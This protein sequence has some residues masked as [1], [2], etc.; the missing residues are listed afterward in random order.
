MTCENDKFSPVSIQ[1]LTS[2][3]NNLVQ[4]RLD[5]LCEHITPQCL[6]DL[7]QSNA[8]L[9]TI[10]IVN[11]DFDS[12]FA[13]L[14]LAKC[15]K[16]VDFSL[17][18]TSINF[19]NIAV[20]HVVLS[21][22]RRHPIKKFNLSGIWDTINYSS[23]ETH[24]SLEIRHC[25][26]VASAD[27]TQ[28]FSEFGGFTELILDSND[29]D[30]NWLLAIAHKNKNNATLHSLEIFCD[31]FNSNFEAFKHLLTTCTLFTKLHFVNTNVSTSQVRSILSSDNYLTHIK[32]D[33][34]RN[35]IS[36]PSLVEMLKVNPQITHFNFVPWCLSDTYQAEI[37]LKEVD[38]V[39]EQWDGL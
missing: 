23:C 5:S 30:N 28:L 22:T 36:T 9:T 3:C 32:F 13:A 21:S 39:V 17:S 20:L 25:R 10:D 37:Y 18:T 4:L 11:D 14:V 27:F 26:E 7:F 31:A 38:R 12:D 19:Q 35:T 6:L 2:F 24:K 33:Y 1:F 29:M 15:E 8:N 16:V 34:V